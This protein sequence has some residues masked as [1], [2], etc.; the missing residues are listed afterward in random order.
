MYI[1]HALINALRTHMI[2]IN[3]NMMFYTHV[4]AL[5]KFISCVKAWRFRWVLLLN[6]IIHPGSVSLDTD[7][8]VTVV[9]SVQSDCNHNRTLTNK[10]QRH[11][12][13][14]ATLHLSLRSGS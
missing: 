11:Q 1:Y 14:Q 5:I 9:F 3:L 7:K 8:N 6:I 2:H 13:P 12:P 10:Q 4:P